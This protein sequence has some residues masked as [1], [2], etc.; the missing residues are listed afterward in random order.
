MV[1]VEKLTKEERLED[2]QKAL[3]RFNERLTFCQP[4]CELLGKIRWKGNCPFI[5]WEDSW[6]YYIEFKNVEVPHRQLY[7]MSGQKGFQNI[8]GMKMLRMIRMNILKTAINLV[9][10]T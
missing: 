8:T 9:N 5:G 7:T 2:Y 3:N 6:E 4:L 1:T 10:Q